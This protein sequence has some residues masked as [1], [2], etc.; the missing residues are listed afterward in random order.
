[1]GFL[2]PLP[3]VF[4]TLPVIL[5]PRVLLQVQKRPTFCLPPL[6][7]PLALD[8]CTFLIPPKVREVRAE[9]LLACPFQLQE[10]KQLRDRRSWCRKSPAQPQR[11]RQTI[12]SGLCYNLQH[13][14]VQPRRGETQRLRSWLNRVDLQRGRERHTRC[15]LAP[16]WL[17]IP[18]PTPVGTNAFQ[19]LKKTSHSRS[20]NTSPV[21]HLNWE[22]EGEK[23]SA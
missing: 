22:R 7:L 18:A 15:A 2:L 21:N 11:G 16:A 14:A 10:P 1:M 20:K 5:R 8:C 6:L 9:E 23:Q 13:A 17:Q 12:Q 4:G 3:V 19:H